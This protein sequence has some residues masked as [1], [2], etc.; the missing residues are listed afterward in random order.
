MWLARLIENEKRY[1]FGYCCKRKICYNSYNQ[2][3]H[4]F[5]ISLEYR[6][7]NKNKKIQNLLKLCHVSSF[8]MAADRW[9]TFRDYAKT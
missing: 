8:S 4:S 6:N 7:I 5:N 2:H 9:L 3:S 1:S